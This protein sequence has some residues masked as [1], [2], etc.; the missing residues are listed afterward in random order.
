MPQAERSADTRAPARY[1]APQTPGIH[2]DDPRTYFNLVILTSLP[3]L[4]RRAKPSRPSGNPAH[5]TY[6]GVAAARL[7]LAD[8][9][10]AVLAAGLALTAIAAVSQ[11]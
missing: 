7:V 8:A 4:K 10:R 9:V 11:L 3:D 1:L 5:N 2:G 6:R